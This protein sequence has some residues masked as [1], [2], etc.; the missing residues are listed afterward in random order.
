[1]G[2]VGGSMD[3]VTIP[4]FVHE[5]V[6]TRMERTNKRLLGVLAVAIAAL[7]IESAI[8]INEHDEE[9]D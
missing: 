5:G 4:Y 8:L 9:D 1:M 3:I 2:C 7:I 6:V